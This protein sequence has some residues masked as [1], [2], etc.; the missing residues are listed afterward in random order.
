MFKSLRWRL[1]FWFV[2]LTSIVYASSALFGMW[3]FRVELTR[4][5]DEELHA[6]AEELRPAIVVHNDIPSLEEWSR[7]SH[8]IPFKFSQSIQLYNSR[9]ALLESYGPHGIPALS[10]AK[11]EFKTDLYRIRNLAT[12]IFDNGNLVGYLQIQ[13]SLKNVQ[14]AIHQFGYTMGCLAPFLLIGLGIAGYVFSAKAAAPVEESFSVLQRFMSDAGHE[15]STPISIIQANAEA[16]EVELPPSDASNKRLAV[17]YRSTDRI[18]NLV[19]D[20]MLLSKMESPHLSKRNS[21]LDLAKLVRGVVEEFQELF[22]SKS[23]ELRFDHTGAA[24][25]VGDA[26]SLKRVIT[27][28]LQNAMRYTDG[29]G[30]VEVK[31]ENL[32]RNLRLTVADTGIGIPAESL[33]HIFD[34]F[35]RVDKS[36]SRVQGGSGLGLSIVKAIVDAH[37]GKIDLRSEVGF[38]TT[39]AIT[40][41]AGK[42]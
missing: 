17:I 18:G 22:K 11:L 29:G 24:P 1:T 39:V 37:R 4:V 26:E 20:L 9:G 7:T 34:R 38:G 23:I 36:R 40:L 28:L 41:P 32:G 3:L 5:I 42:N 15:L 35:Y 13:L 14:H 10:L 31:L 30:L 2:C 27:N 16:M 8:K 25:I 6:L 12:P 21:T 19:S 33:P